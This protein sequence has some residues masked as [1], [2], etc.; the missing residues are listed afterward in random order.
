MD[1]DQIAYD[2]AV[3]VHDIVNDERKRNPDGDNISIEADVKI[4]GVQDVIR[5]TSNADISEDA[6]TP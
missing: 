3:R 6:G 4:D 1:A 2:L 5:E